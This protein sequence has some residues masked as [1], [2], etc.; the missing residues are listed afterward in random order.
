MKRKYIPILLSVALALIALLVSQALWLRYASEQDSYRQDKAFTA[1]FNRSVSTLIRDNMEKGDATPYKSRKTIDKETYKKLTKG[2]K[3]HIIDAGYPNEGDN[4][5]VVFENALIAM[6]IGQ[7]KF[8]L[9]KLDSLIVSCINEEDR[10]VVSSHIILQDIKENKVLDEVQRQYTSTYGSFQAKTY[11]VDRLIE[12][13]NH[14]YLI[15]AE[16]SI[17]QPSYL[18]RLGAVTTI[19]F[20]ATIVIALVLFYLIFMLSRRF[21][22]ILDMERSFHGAVHDLKSPLAYVLFMLSRLEE[23]ET[24]MDKRNSLSIGAAR[25]DFLA[26]K[27][28]RLLMFARDIKKVK[29]SDKTEVSLYDILEQ[30]EE[31]IYTVFSNKKISFEHDID[32]DYVMRVQPDLMEAAIRIIIENAVKYNGSE[33]IVKIAATS[34][35]DNQ[36]ITITDNGVGMNRQQIK[37]VFKSYYSSDKKKGN[38]IGLYYAHSIVKAHGGVISAQSEE[39]VGSTFVI[40]LPN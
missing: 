29:E 28:R 4:V 31:E 30:I 34:G 37:R 25:V 2:K 13:P 15:E 24:D 5:A 10:E 9:T 38:G 35:T 8:D 32:T 33:P 22:E 6:K 16:Y 40:T 18:I 27:I 21:A 17:K 26:D 19:S 11:A 3:V 20:I 36:T 7:E 1:C 12:L 39:G 14:T 23:N